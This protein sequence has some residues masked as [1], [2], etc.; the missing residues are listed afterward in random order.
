M[1]IPGEMICVARV[2]NED[3]DFLTLEVGKHDAVSFTL[4]E[5]DSFHTLL[6]VHKEGEGLEVWKPWE[7]ET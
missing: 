5:G 3:D 6:F 7:A 2:L 1:R 4:E